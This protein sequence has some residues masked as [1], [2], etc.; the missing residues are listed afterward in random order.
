MTTPRDDIVIVIPARFGS[1]RFPGKPLA[2]ILGRSMLERTYRIAKAV[3]A[4]REVYVTTDD[5]RIAEHARAFG[6]EVIEVTAPCQNGTERVA[7][8]VR[9]LTPRPSAAVNLQGDAVLTPPWVVAALVESLRLTHGVVTPAVL[10]DEARLAELVK[11]KREAPA[12]G[13]TVVF[14]HEHR[15]LYF[16][17][18]VLPFARSTQSHPVFRHVGIY[19]YDTE[20]LLRLAA[21]PPSRLELSE[22]LEQLRALE[23]GI[24]VRVVEVDYRG[25]THVS[26][27][28]P[29]DL[30]LAEAAILREGELV[31]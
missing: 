4:V 19:G 3:P 7:L 15:A 17:K 18:H 21:L 5:G 22:G 8:A 27:D 2:R 16:S 29:R 26:I 1:T 31:I 12:S 25:R 24:P 13:T 30:K 20:T 14:D 10:L 9:A 11:S 23:N 28:D 6:A